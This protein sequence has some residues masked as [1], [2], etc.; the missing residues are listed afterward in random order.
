MAHAPAESK[1]FRQSVAELTPSVC[2]DARLEGTGP[3]PFMLRVM[4]LGLRLLACL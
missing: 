2:H 4:R 3:L 1:A